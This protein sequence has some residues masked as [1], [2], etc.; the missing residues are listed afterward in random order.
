MPQFAAAINY[1]T[2]AGVCDT[3][4]AGGKNNHACETAEG[5]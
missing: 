5:D 1:A 3:R 2:A 4:D